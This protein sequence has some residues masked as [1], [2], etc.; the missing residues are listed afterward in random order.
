MKLKEGHLKRKKNKN[1]QKIPNDLATQI[2]KSK[3]KSWISTIKTP[4]QFTEAVDMRRCY[5]CL[6]LPLQMLMLRASKQFIALYLVKSK[7]Y[8]STV[9]KNGTNRHKL[10][11]VQSKSISFNQKQHK[12][13]IAKN[14]VLAFCLRDNLSTTLF[15]KHDSKTVKNK[16]CIQKR[17]SKEYLSNLH[18]KFLAEFPQH[19]ISL[20]TFARLSPTYCMLANFL[21]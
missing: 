18:T 7:G 11:R 5:I 12:G 4:K 8:S 14:K 10:S 15:G 16:L 3:A 21:K 19:Q 2:L 17:T 1:K 9:T 20:S 13:H 6:K